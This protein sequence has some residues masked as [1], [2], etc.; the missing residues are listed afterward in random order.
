[1][2]TFGSDDAPPEILSVRRVRECDIFVGIY[3]QRYGTVDPSTGKSITELEFDE[4]ERA[5]SG[6]TLNGILLYLLE[7]DARWPEKYIQPDALSVEKL[8]RLKQRI[9]RHAV[10]KFRNPNDLPFMIIK[11]VLAKIRG[12]V[13][14]N[15]SGRPD[16]AQPNESVFKI[17][18]GRSSMK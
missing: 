17:C 10:T 9:L 13:F 7:D 8:S 16:R 5:L 12:L 6:G 4:A 14:P 11:D 1:M 2:E 15:E 18:F 3:A